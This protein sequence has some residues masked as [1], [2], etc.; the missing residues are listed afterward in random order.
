MKKQGR[1][2]HWLDEPQYRLEALGL[3]KARR[4]SEG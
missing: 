1:S 3:T 4:I 2:N